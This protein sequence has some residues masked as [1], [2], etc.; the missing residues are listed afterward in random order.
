MF[1]VTAKESSTMRELD[2]H[3]YFDLLCKD[4]I[5]RQHRVLDIV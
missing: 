2:D 1:L 5:K 4:L 3:G